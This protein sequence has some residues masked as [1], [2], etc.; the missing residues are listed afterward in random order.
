MADQSNPWDPLGDSSTRNTLPTVASNL[1]K[2]A[3]ADNM[4]TVSNLCSFL[5]VD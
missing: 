5:L 4:P 3:M 2:L 1:E